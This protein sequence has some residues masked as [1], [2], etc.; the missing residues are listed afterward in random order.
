[1]PIDISIEAQIGRPVAEVAAFVLH[2]V[3]ETKWIRGIEESMPLTADP[4]GPGSRVL[5]VAKFMG[6]RI[7]YTLEVIEFEPNQRLLM[8]T[9]VPFPMTIRYTFSERASERAGGT[10]FSQRLRG[11]PTGM[12]GL[13]S[14]LV[15]MM[16]RRSVR[17]DMERLRLL[18][19]FPP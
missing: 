11:G 8:E 3:N 17:A 13:L 1:M 10:A 12:M 2:P 19:E 18:L 14:P 9:R 7:E 16:V 15:A 5:R 4:L 6:R